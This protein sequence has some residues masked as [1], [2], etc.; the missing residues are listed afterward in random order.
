MLVVGANASA[1]H[2]AGDPQPFGPTARQKERRHHAILV[3]NAA[4]ALG[5]GGPG[6]ADGALAMFCA[7]RQASLDQA[8]AGGGREAWAR[9]LANRALCTAEERLRA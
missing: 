9:V 4:E 2:R 7:D 8:S 6:A 3:R 1:A 5:S